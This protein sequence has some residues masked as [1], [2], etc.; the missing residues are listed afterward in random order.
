M[1]TLS[2]SLHRPSVGHRLKLRIQARLGDLSPSL[3]YISHREG[4]AAKL[5]RSGPPNRAGR[6]LH[7]A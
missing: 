7:R 1:L 3:V 6:R 5:G 2:P 4:H